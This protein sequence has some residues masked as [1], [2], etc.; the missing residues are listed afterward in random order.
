[1]GEPGA[2]DEARAALIRLDRHYLQ[3]PVVG[4]WY[5]QFDRDGRSLVDWIPA[6]S[7]YHVLTAIAE[8]ERVLG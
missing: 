6:S 7:F 2:A 5:D 1:V 3:H 8:A 4:G